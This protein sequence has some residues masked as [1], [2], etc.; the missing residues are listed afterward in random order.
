MNKIFFFFLFLFLISSAYAYYSGESIEVYSLGNCNYLDVNV[1]STLI[2]EEGE[3]WLEDCN[4][5]SENLWHCDC[6]G[7]FVLVMDTLENS[8]NNYS[9]GIYYAYSV[10]EPDESSGDSG[11]SGGGSSGHHRGSHNT[12]YDY[13]YEENDTEEIE[14]TVEEEPKQEPEI[15]EEVNETVEVIVPVEEKTNWLFIILLLLFG[16]LFVGGLVY[17]FLR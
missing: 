16:I 4:Q 7:S 11:S 12:T 2:I 17:Y 8:Y 15:T 6:N 9:I 1:S 13:D 3:Y 14:I 10:E 5:T